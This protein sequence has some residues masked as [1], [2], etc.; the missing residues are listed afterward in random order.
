MTEYTILGIEINAILLIQESYSLLFIYL[1]EGLV[2]IVE[3]NL[4]INLL[5]GFRIIIFPL[6]FNSIGIAAQSITLEQ[7]I[8]ND[9]CSKKIVVLGELPN[10]GE[11]LAFQ[12]KA[13]IVKALVK[14]CDFNAI[15][16]EAPIYDFLGFQESVKDNQATFLQLERAIGGFWL[17]KGLAEWRNW[18]FSKAI[19]EQLYIGGL[20][21]QVSATSFHARATLPSLVALSVPEKNKE[22]CQQAVSRNLFWQYNASQKFNDSE[23]KLLQ[24]CLQLAINPTNSSQKTTNINNA[25]MMLINLANLYARQ[26]QSEEAMDRDAI[27]YHNFQKQTK[28]SIEQKIIIWTATVHGARL[29]GLLKSK[30]LGAWLFEE[31]GEQLAVIGFTAFT[32]NSSRAGTAE[33]LIPEAPANSLEAVSTKSGT[34]IAYLN[35]VALQEKGNIISRLFGGMNLANWADY[36]DGVV[37][38]REEVAPD[39]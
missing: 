15:Y 10:H 26:F 25:Q 37:V 24:T 31:W 30:P 35:K 19:T 6:L 34:Q 23:Q 3:L 11:S 18:L 17:T 12:S 38:I 4:N 20:D 28:N 7:Q 16:F 9:Y 5:S 39:F 29:Q 2:K 8:V 1:K 21:D 27:M 14:Q 22:K 33:K 32:G 13:K 36:F